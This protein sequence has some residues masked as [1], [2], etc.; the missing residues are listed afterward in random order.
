MTAKDYL[1]QIRSLNIKIAMREEESALLKSQ[2]EGT[3]SQAL[4][5][6]KVQTSISGDP[7]GDRLARASDIDAE[8]QWLRNRLIA[9]RH[10]IIGQI[11]QLED[12]RYVELLKLKYVGRTEYVDG[13]PHVHY[14][15][16]EEIAC[17]MVKSNG[18]PYSYEHIR[19]LHG[20]ALK[21]F[22]EIM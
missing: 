6:D 10:R 1:M 13:V 18:M 21:R 9:D 2:A 4:S 5:P 12:A 16:L 20:E 11:E 15:R 22:S 8:V 7:M 14:L 17:V 19:A 3:G